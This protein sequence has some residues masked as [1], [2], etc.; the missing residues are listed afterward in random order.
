MDG[1]QAA[2][3]QTIGRVVSCEGIGLHSGR[4]V[5]IRLCP[6][7]PNTGIRFLRRTQT[8]D[9]WIDARIGQ[10]SGTTLATSLGRGEKVVHTVEH[11]LAAASGLR[12]D[13]LVV[14]LD[15]DEIPIMDGSARPFADALLGAGIASQAAPR[16]VFVVTAPFE[17]RDG[18]GWI[19]VVPSS[20]LEVYNTVEYDHPAIGRQVFG[21][22]DDGPSTFVESL[23][24]ARTF[25]FLRDVERLKAAGLIQG[26]SL[27]NAVVVG[28]TGVLN[29]EGL[30]WDDEFVRHK[31]LDLLGDLALLGGTMRGRITAF[32]AGHGLHSK[33]VAYMTAH[34]E[35]WQVQ[36]AD[37][38]ATI[39]A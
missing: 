16:S 17:V 34:P 2:S 8:G 35:V 9:V 29:E 26:G 7:E 14:E 21:Y 13:N 6:A 30:R 12:L 28:A 33:F 37:C 15:A 25:G 31:T 18:A 36:I 38:E 3:Q 10:V 23:A 20:R 11:L 27:D 32:K 1:F 19:S 22:I 24:G 5:S 39:S 4:Q